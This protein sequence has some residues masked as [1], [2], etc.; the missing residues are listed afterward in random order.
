MN[1]RTSGC[2]PDADVHH[3]IGCRRADGLALVLALFVMLLLSALAAGLALVTA[4]EATIAHNFKNGR[5]ALYAADAAA[6]RAIADLDVLPDWSQVLGGAVQS[7]VVDGPPSGTRR[8]ADGSLIDLGELVN[9][10]NCHKKTM[11][12]A[13]EMDSVTAERPWALNNPRWRAFLYGRL[14]DFTP[15]QTVDSP[16]YVLAMV[17]DDPAETDADPMRDSD[18]PAAGSGVLI[19]RV[20]AFGPRGVLRT[21]ELTVARTET[22]HVRVIAW[23]PY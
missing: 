13:A 1:S 5:E 22:G 2:P 18:P 4:S 16:Y 15:G 6:E 20:H 10:A 11:C 21:I 17:G 19:L 23:R 7:T 12:T 14:A 3:R 8:L 9:L